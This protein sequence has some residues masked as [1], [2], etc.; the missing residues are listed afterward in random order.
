MNNQ[1]VVTQVKERA[2]AMFLTLGYELVDLKY[3]KTPEGMM[4]QFFVDR[5]EG[6]IT[7]GECAQLNHS[8]SKML[9]EESL[10]NEKHILEVSSP[11]LDRPLVGESDF[12]RVVNSNVQI[13]LKE[14][15]L[16][17]LEYFGRIIA[18]DIQGVC[19]DIENFG[20]I[21]IQF[22]KINKAKRVIE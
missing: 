13:F 19:L 4:L 7:L 10:I 3:Y 8:I 9:D 14:P 2:Q 22:S 17:K 5:K 18:V 12:R 11:G 16:G 20:Q 21:K 15:I 1:D 6:G